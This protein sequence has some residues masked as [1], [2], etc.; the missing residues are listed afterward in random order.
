MSFL[1]SGLSAEPFLPLYGLADAELA[2]LGVRRVVADDSAPCRVTLENAPVGAP[3]LLIN[4]EHQA[5]P[6]DYRGSGPIFVREGALETRS[7]GGIPDN[8]R[9][10]L[11]SARAYDS[12]DSMIDA[13]VAPGTELESLIDRLLANRDAAYLHLHHARRGCYACR[14]DRI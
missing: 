3:V 10:R 2:A 14:V 7:T 1:L 8:F 13:D 6:S 11:Y 4:F 12:D 5:A 9:A